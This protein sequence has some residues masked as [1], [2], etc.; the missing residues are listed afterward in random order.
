LKPSVTPRLAKGAFLI[1]HSCSGASAQPVAFA[2]F[3]THR[4]FPLRDAPANKAG[5]H[6]RPAS[7]LM[8]QRANE[9]SSMTE[10]CVVAPCD[11]GRMLRSRAE[12]IVQH[13]PFRGAALSRN[14]PMSLDVEHEKRVV[15]L[16]T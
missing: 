14:N 15:I 9:S 4:A 16:L 5:C 11:A 8:C 1:V 7:G 2:R 6:V 10:P 3:F 13:V 12:F